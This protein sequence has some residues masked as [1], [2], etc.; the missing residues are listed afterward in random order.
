VAALQEGDLHGDRRTLWSSLSLILF[1]SS[2]GFLEV[3]VCSR[4]RLVVFV[5]VDK[6]CRMAAIKESSDSI[7][8]QISLSP[9]PDSLRSP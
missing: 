5:Y 6:I 9:A 7:R 2:S 8:V 1:P 4:D 3:L